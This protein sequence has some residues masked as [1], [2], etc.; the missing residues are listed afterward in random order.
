[1]AEE[2]KFLD[3]KELKKAMKET[4]R[5]ERKEERRLKV[6]KAKVWLY[7]NQNLIIFV[8]VPVMTT[9]AAAVTKAVRAVNRKANL[10]KE[11]DL[12]ELYCY[13]RSLGH[14]WR[15]K[16]ALTNAE[17]VE[18]DKRL[19]TGERLADILDELRVLK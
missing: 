14:Y 3:K 9:T 8:G 5:K 1:M 15:L 10:K 16:R 2:I 6:T 12:K 18:I 19:H 13:D 4:R 17:W 7:Q 11:K